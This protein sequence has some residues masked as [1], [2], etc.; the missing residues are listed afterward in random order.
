MRSLLLCCLV[1]GFSLAGSFAD[2]T[3][4]LVTDRSALG[5]DDSA[6]WASLGS[7]GAH[8]ST[9]AFVTSGAGVTIGVST[10]AGEVFRHDQGVD[11]SGNFSPG[12]ALVFDQNEGGWLQVRFS[13][14]VLGIGAQIQ[15]NLLRS[16]TAMLSVFSPDDVL[17]G[18]FA[19]AGQSTAAG[20]GS[21]L[22]LGVLSDVPIGRVRFDTVGPGGAIDAGFA[23]D[24][25][26]L[27]DAADPT[28][29]PEPASALLLAGG[30][31]ALGYLRCRAA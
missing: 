28:A 5:A 13:R 27:V 29:V 6:S 18:S 7:P 24:G 4:I 8:I 23:I 10:P 14:P 20:D 15:E 9:P 21:A 3:E 2:A 11:W 22:F 12:A 26:S 25:L 1:A 17:L 30:L 16:F 19:V 31:L